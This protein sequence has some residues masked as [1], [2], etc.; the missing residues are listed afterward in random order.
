[1][2]ICSLVVRI[3]IQVSGTVKVQLTDLRLNG[4]SES[5][6][7]YLVDYTVGRDKCARGYDRYIN[8]TDKSLKGY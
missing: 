6:V 3:Y 1:M 2:G 8:V 5:R 4:T 7:N